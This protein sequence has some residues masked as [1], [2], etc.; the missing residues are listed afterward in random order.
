MA[1]V[2]EDPTREVPN[3]AWVAANA[4]MRQAQAHVDQ[5]QAQYG[6]EALASQE[7]LRPTMRGFKIANAKLGLKIRD[8][9]QRLS[10][11]QARRTK[12]PRRVPIQ[13]AIKEPVIKLAPER[14]HLTNLIKMVAFQ[15]ESDLFRL[16]TP[17]Y[18]RASDEGRTLLQSVFNGAADIEVAQHELRLTLVPMSSAHKTRAIA[19]L[20]QE[21]NKSQ[22]LFPGSNLRMHYAIREPS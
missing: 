19:A 1:S 21:L 11:L 13:E 22:T 12:L 15:A 6:L 8:A 7:N 20:C 2:P 3:P 5:L 14:K 17:H 18:P 10:R 4:Q 9:L 16:L